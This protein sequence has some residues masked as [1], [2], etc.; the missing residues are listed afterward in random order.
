MEFDLTKPYCYY[1]NEICKIPHGSY[2]EKTISDYVVSFAK[3]HHLRYIQDAMWNVVIY[4]DASDGY[5]D[6]DPVMLQGHLDMV[7]EAVAGLDFDFETQ[8]I[9]TYVDEEGRLRAKGTTLG[10]DD[11]MGVAQ[12]LAILADDSLKHPPLE[13]V[14]TVQEEV[15]L[16]GA[17]AM[18]KSLLHSHRMISLDGGGE[19]VT[20]ISSAGGIQAVNTI[21]C[22]FKKQSNHCYQLKVTGLSGGHSGGEIHK[23]KGNANKLVA[24]ILKEMMNDGVDVSLVSFNGGAKDNAIPRESI[25]IFASKNDAEY[26][27]DL[28]KEKTEK[29][30]VEFEH[31]DPGFQTI[32]ES[33][34]TCNE[35]MDQTSTKHV[36]DYLYLLDNG[37]QHRSMAIEGLTLT[38]LN[39][40]IVKTEGTDVICNS[41]IRSAL[42]EAIDDDVDHIKCLASY[43]GGNVE[44]MARYPAWN[45][46]PNSKMRETFKKVFASLYDGKHLQENAGHGGLECAVFTQVDGGMDIITCGPVSHGCHT[47]DEFLDL[48]SFD[49]A[50]TLLTTIIANVDKKA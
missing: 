9:E 26:L 14:F 40:G 24:R 32:F 6:Y 50:Y 1:F 25:A 49:R 23:E 39:L 34:E 41:S 16:C 31:S 4:K 20:G 46:G 47:P 48:A 27:K 5:R 19:V 37:F 28:V 42:E 21:A 36:I 30:S 29:I 11:G 3:E 15:G 22:T 8:P 33:A 13:C 7:C 2:H 43:T 12:M 17:L 38:S 45:Y 35:C 18:D 44:T 10:A